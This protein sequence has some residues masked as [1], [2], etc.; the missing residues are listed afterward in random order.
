MA[1]WARKL[2]TLIVA[3]VVLGWAYGAAV[4]RVYGPDETPGFWLGV[5]HGAL[6]PAALPS[7]LMGRDVPIFA[8]RNTGRGYKIG[9]IAGIN[10]CGLFFFGIAF[11]PPAK[12]AEV[13]TPGG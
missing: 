7:L 2:A 12:R 8:G 3:G 13:A 5:A 1:R 4:P 10:L 11:R 6:M 9:Y